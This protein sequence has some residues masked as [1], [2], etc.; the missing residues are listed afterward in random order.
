MP[1]HTAENRSPHHWPPQFHLPSLPPAVLTFCT[2]TPPM[3]KISSST[4]KQT[5]A[6]KNSAKTF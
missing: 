5:F 1:F 6:T 4:H 3:Y 2:F